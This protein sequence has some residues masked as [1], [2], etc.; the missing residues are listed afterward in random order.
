MQYLTK[1]YPRLST[2]ITSWPGLFSIIGEAI[3]GDM[4]I[5]NTRV[6]L[7]WLSKMLLAVRRN[8]RGYVGAIIGVT[9]VTI[10][11]RVLIFRMLFLTDVSITTIA[12]GYLLFVLIIAS[13]QG[14]G[15]S[16]FASLISTFCFNFFFLPPPFYAFSR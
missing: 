15:P 10:I 12:L 3:L 8:W 9:T 2:G 16:I 6:A 13:K 7:W 1:G 14:H 5:Q 11:F 4:Q